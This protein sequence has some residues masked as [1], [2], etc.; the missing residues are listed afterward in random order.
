MKCRICG[1]DTP[2]GKKLCKDCAA[3]RK[4]AFAA[5]VTQPLLLAA[6]GAPSVSQPRFAPKPGGA[7]RKLSVVRGEQPAKPAIEHKRTPVRS[8]A[9][10]RGPHVLWLVAG[11]AAALGVVLVLGMLAARREVPAATDE[12]HPRAPVAKAQPE[13][14]TPVAVAPASR[15]PLEIE[16]EPVLPKPPQHHARKP[17]PAEPVAAPAPVEAAP[18]TVPEPAPRAAPTQRP[19]EVAV[20]ADPLQSLNE[21]LTRCVREAMFD[22]PACEQSARARYCGASWGSIPQC[23]IGPGTDH[24]Q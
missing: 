14:V 7:Q 23:P 20:R 12:V 8:T 21:A 1:C 18:A 6:V 16:S 11:S 9:A 4:R 24:G 19:V 10:T 2:L 17:A 22:R 5:T 13:T 3:A 15:P